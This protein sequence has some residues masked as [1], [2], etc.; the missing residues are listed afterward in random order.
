MG[1]IAFMPCNAV[2]SV[3]FVLYVGKLDLIDEAINTAFNRTETT[4]SNR[5]KKLQTAIQLKQC[6][7]LSNLINRKQTKSQY[8]G[9][10]G[11][12]DEYRYHY[13]TTSLL[14]VF[15]RNF[16]ASSVNMRQ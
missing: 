1:S 7:P 10:R 16:M 4:K 12:G 15:C 2:S 6:E 11:P 13:L 5:T 8:M 14:P 9:D 3:L